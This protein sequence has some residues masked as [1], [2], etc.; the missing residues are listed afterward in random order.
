MNKQHI[1]N[2]IK[3][4]AE[5]NDGKALGRERFETVTGITQGQWFG[6]YWSR[7]GDAVREAGFEANTWQKALPDDEIIRQLVAL[8]RKRGHYPTHGAMRL[9]EKTDPNF[10]N[11]GVF[12]RLGSKQ[13]L[14]QKVTEYCEANPGNDDVASICAP[15][16]TAPTNA[17][18]DK[19]EEFETGYVYLALMKVGREKRYK[20]G[21]ANLVEQRTRQVAVNLPEDL[22]L[23]HAISTDDA[24]GIEGYWHRRF[25]QQRRGG[26][27]FELTADDVRVFKRR[28]FM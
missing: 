10:P 1:L 25:A 12:A 2:E 22:E 26:E 18:A 16:V 24:Y 7:W 17:T 14:I 27:W 15:L 28:K 21:K 8:I 13:D 23:I 3:R 11:H 9:H 4:T 19:L 5:E 6:R 20:I